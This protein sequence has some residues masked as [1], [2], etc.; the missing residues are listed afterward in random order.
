MDTGLINDIIGPVT[1]FQD[2]KWRRRT[3]VLI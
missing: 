3:G 2:E 1:H